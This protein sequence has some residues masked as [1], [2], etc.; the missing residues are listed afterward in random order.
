MLSVVAPLS[1]LSRSCKKLLQA[2][3]IWSHL[4]EEVNRGSRYLTAVLA[5]FPTPS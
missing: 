1:E 2:I 3:V 5:E 4:S